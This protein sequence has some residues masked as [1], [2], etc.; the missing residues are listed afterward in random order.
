[1]K[2][3]TPIHTIL[4]VNDAPDVLELLSAMMRREGYRVLIADRAQAGL[5]LAFS[6]DPD[7][8]ICDVVMP[9]LDGIQFCRLLK[10]DPRSKHVPIMLVS[11]LRTDDEATLTGLSAGAD[12]YLPIP[13]RRQELLVKVARLVE[14]HRLE[15]H[16]RELVERSADIIYTQDLIGSLTS[17]NEAG[18]RFF[19]RAVEE[20]VGGPVKELLGA[21]PLNGDRTAS[22]QLTADGSRR[23]VVAL[24]NS[25][26][27]THFFD[28]L[29]SLVTDSSGAAQGVRAVLRD[30][31][32]QRRAE[33]ALQESQVRFRELF[34]DANDLIYTHDLE[35]NFT[36]LNKA[37]ERITGYSRA[38]AMGMNITEVITPEYLDLARNMTTAKSNGGSSTTYELDIFAKDGHRVSLE[39]SS[40][41]MEENGRPVGVQGI[42]RDITE[43][44]RAAAALRL[45]EERYR[46]LFENANDMIYTHDLTGNYLSV[47]KACERISGYSKSELMTMNIAQLAAPGFLDLAKQMTALKLQAGSSTSY[48]FEM[49]VKGGHRV[50]IEVN[51]RLIFEHG[52]PVGV[53]GIARDITERK[54]ASVAIAQQAEREAIINRI[55]TAVRQSLDLD[56]IFRTS[57]AELGSHLHVDRC[58]FF[59]LEDDGKLARNV[60]EYCAEGAEPVGMN[61]SLAQLGEIERGLDHNGVLTVSDVANEPGLAGVYQKVLRPRGVRSIMYVT[62]NLGEEITGAITLS[63]TKQKRRWEY[64]DVALVKAVANQTGLAMR[65]ARLL[66]R[67]E[68]TSAREALIN[69]LSLA[70]R[71]S[72]SL[73]EVLDTATRELGKALSTSR[74][75]LRF[76]GSGETRAPIEHEFVAPEIARI[77]DT[78]SMHEGIIAQTLRQSSKLVINDALT[79]E[80]FSEELRTAVRDQVEPDGF[81]SAIFCPVVINSR[82]RG[83]LC[84]HQT[85]RVR[86]WTDDEVALVEAVAA[87]LATGIAQAELFEITRRAKKEWETTFNAMSDGVFIFDRNNQLIRVNRAGAAM[88]DSW[89]HLLLGRRCCDILRSSH[90]DSDCVVEEVLRE[91]RSVNVELVPER[92]NRPLV[93]S[94]EPLI[95]AENGTIGVVCTARDLSDLR[96]VEAIARERQ[97]LLTNILES[98]RE[99]ICAIDTKGNFMWCNNATVSAIGLSSEELIGSSFLDLIFAADRELAH[100]NFNLALAGTPCTFEARYQTQAEEIRYALIDNAPLVIDD[101]TIGVL[102]I[103]RDVTEQKEQGQRAA[104]ADKLRALGRLASGVAHDFNNALAAV[105]GRAQL[106]RRQTTNV[107][108]LRNLDIIQTAAEDAAA[109]VRRIQVFARQ[110]P[111]SEFE[112]VEV[113]GL[114]RDS[115]EITRTR[116]ENE[117]LKSGLHVEV[118]VQAEGEF[119]MPGNASELREVFVNLIVN[120][121]DA[122]PQGGKVLITCAR[123]DDHLI[124]RFVDTGMGM[125]DD[126]R[127]RIF[128]PFY[129]TKGLQGTGLGLAVSYSIIERHQGSISV[130]SEP[131]RGTTFEIELPATDAIQFSE[132][133]VKDETTGLSLSILV[134]DDEDFVRDT[135]A[136]MLDALGHKVIT[137]ANGRI[138]LEILH[139]GKFD[140]VFTD[141]SMP[142]MDGWEVA[143]EVRRHWPGLNIVMVTGYGQA[144]RYPSGEED[145]V[146]SVIGKPFDFSQISATVA[147]VTGKRP[148]IGGAPPNIIDQHSDII[149]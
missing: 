78:G 45:S 127:E 57:V 106:M 73:T 20:I 71:A 43:R 113:V 97:S 72:L 13:F 87:Q 107:G 2:P 85:D 14:R 6:Q 12:D 26:G 143:R 115:K 147:A 145:L 79:F 95:D 148:V 58:T 10:H 29:V 9:E 18:A 142:E 120:A 144:T 103:A 109:T 37:G 81:R 74:V 102:W 111:S 93:I 108:M 132:P 129:T 80:G 138:A 41:L 47:N 27:T 69:R 114:L 100:E 110:S 83:A 21:D 19:N 7:L 137:A 101:R 136:D 64:A 51:S 121:V 24:T 125:P 53:Q 8:I 133:A 68:A 118:E 105:L 40:R 126:V 99:P 119:Y 92:L 5:E 123:R 67:A 50:A 55:S 116:W 96:K 130:A 3:S 15:K 23:D 134:I 28:S 84:I 122:M 59:L 52:E 32:E 38:E 131:K 17:I 117:A 42:A 89:P 1:M 98:V 49:V 90:D 146:D 112:I 22:G 35:G 141:L 44:K 46:D 104:Q 61:F 65:Q 86:R 88:E 60:A 140:L 91:G 128:E 139:A 66:E 70:I 149:N 94:G 4:V 30:I 48:E 25:E 11:G 75:Y 16:Y 39:V 34:E 63:T 33:S 36:S 76:Y 56:K 135:L 62:V 82:F 124:L 77:R 31:T 54:Q